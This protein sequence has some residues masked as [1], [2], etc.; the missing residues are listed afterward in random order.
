[1]ISIHKG[2]DKEN[3]KNI[4]IL[5]KDIINDL[6]NKNNKNIMSKNK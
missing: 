1:M 3:E 6:N 5:I 4:G 2:Y